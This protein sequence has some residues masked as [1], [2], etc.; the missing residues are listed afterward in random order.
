MTI[1][2][3]I[4]ELFIDSPSDIVGALGVVLIWKLWN[5]NEIHDD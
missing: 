1:E 3:L 2:N 4:D 5:L